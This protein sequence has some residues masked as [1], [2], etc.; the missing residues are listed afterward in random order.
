M[1]NDKRSSISTQ[2]IHEHKSHS[3]GPKLQRLA[4]NGLGRLQ[5]R[6]KKRK[7]RGVR[8]RKRDR[9]N[10][11]SNSSRTGSNRGGQ[12]LRGVKRAAGSLV[13]VKNAAQRGGG[14]SN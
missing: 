10:L 4:K 9:V 1:S 11:M 13:G 14:S 8:Q 6:P 12:T 5:K 3:D 7:T 2:D